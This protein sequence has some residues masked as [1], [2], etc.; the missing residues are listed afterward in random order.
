MK[1]KNF[2]PYLFMSATRSKRPHMQRSGPGVSL[3]RNLRAQLLRGD[4]KNP[5]SPALGSNKT[6]IA[7][8]QLRSAHPRWGGPGQVWFQEK[9]MDQDPLCPHQCTH[10]CTRSP[11]PATKTPKEAPRRQE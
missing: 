5:P 11:S 10:A 9:E 8:K 1:I 4:G 2:S 7:G 3:G 6:E